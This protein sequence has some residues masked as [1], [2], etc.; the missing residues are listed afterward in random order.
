MATVSSPRSR[1]QSKTTSRVG[2][3]RN[4]SQGLQVQPLFCPTTVVDPFDT[5][6]WTLR[7]AQIKDENG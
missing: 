6:K 4:L 3:G 7:S 1:E 5:V 2:S